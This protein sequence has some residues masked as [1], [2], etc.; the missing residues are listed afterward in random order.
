MIIKNGKII[1]R[2]DQLLP[3]D[4]HELGCASTSLDLQVCTWKDPKNFILSVMKE[5]YANMLK[6]DNHFYI[7]GRNS[8]ENKDLL[9]VKYHPQQLCNKP[10][11]VYPTTY[12]SMFVAIHHGG[13]TVKTGAKINELGPHFSQ[14]QNFAFPSKSGNLYDYKL[15]LNP[16]DPYNN[17]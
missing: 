8:S 17:Y 12:D 7:V 11:Y 9:E 14:Y 4:L 6:I 15:Q 16:G 2:N 10:T 3:C 5:D 13:F 1:N